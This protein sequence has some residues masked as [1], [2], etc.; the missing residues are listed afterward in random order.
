MDAAGPVDR[1][2]S[3]GPMDRWDRATATPRLGGHER[4]VTLRR[5][6]LDACGQRRRARNSRHASSLCS[7]AQR[8]QLAQ[9]DYDVP[10][11]RS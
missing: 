5:V 7:I 6:L 4:G 11:K 1:G 2:R 8:T 10:V 3:T 9:Q